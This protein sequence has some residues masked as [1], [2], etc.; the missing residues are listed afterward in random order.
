[1]YVEVGA[2]SGLDYPQGAVVVGYN[3]KDHS[4]AALLWAA[5]EVA[6]TDAPMVVLYAANYS[7]M[8][9]EPG[10]GLFERDPLALEAAEEVTARGIEEALQAQPGLVVAGATEVTSPSRALTEAAAGAAL[11]VLGSRGYGQVLGA[12]LGSVAFAVAARAPC[13]VIVVKDE[14][15]DRRAGP[16]APRR[17]WHRRLPRSLG[18]ARLRRPERRRC[19]R[20]ARGGATH[21]GASGR[22]H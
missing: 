20:A 11:I 3:G 19:L 15:P 5:E 17:R 14:S 16:G 18:R 6:R 1:M 22:E 12:L 10:P 2:W 9:V 8:T 7:G 13:P 21:R 4:R